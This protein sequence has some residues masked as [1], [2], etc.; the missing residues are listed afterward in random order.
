RGS[1]ARRARTL[2]AIVDAT[3]DARPT[4]DVGLA[5]VTAALGA[6]PSA[7]SGLFAVARSAGWLAHVLEQ[8]AA[9]FLLRPRARYTGG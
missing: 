7:A 2:L 1:G 4:A 6:P 5:A 8:R 9:G 3:P